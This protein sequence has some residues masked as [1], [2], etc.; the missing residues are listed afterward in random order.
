MKY[1]GNLR[2]MNN[3]LLKVEYPVYWSLRD[4]CEGFRKLLDHLQLDKVVLYIFPIG[5]LFKSFFLF[6][7]VNL[8]LKLL[9]HD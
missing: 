2:L 8:F 5:E 7:D 6:H 9:F 3:G 4:W 1:T